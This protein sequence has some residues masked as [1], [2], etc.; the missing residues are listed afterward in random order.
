ML[1]DDML[2]DLENVW[3]ELP[4]IVPEPVIDPAPAIELDIYHSF[5]R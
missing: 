5:E 4:L 3:P 2:R 1:T